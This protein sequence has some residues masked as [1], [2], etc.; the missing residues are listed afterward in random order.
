VQGRNLEEAIK[1]A[2]KFTTEAV[3]LTYEDINGTKYGV[4]FE[5]AIPYLIKLS[6][7]N[8]SKYMIK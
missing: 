6:N 5:Q 2:T 7:C 1:I 8:M 4:N 3:R